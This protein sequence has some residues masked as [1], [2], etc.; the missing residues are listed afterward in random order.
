V[1]PLPPIL[2]LLLFP[3]QVSVLMPSL[4]DSW[5]RMYIV[6]CSAPFSLPVVSV[7][8]LRSLFPAGLP[9]Q[10]PSALFPPLRPPFSRLFVQLS[11][12]FIVCSFSLLLLFS[13]SSSRLWCAETCV[14]ALKVCRQKVG[15]QS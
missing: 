13:F 7:S 5:Y 11:A 2:L 6:P 8:P 15:F 3:F 1:P 14:V 12:S 9:L 10:F 4:S